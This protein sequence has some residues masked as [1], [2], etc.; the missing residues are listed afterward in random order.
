MQNI[1]LEKFEGPLDLLLELIERQKLDICEVALAQVTDQYI[2]ILNQREFDSGELA[3][4][5]L[6]ASRLLLIKS[7]ALLPLLNLTEEEEEEIRDLETALTEYR[8]YKNQAKVVKEILAARNLVLTRSL[9][10]GREMFFLPP[11]NLSL[12]LM[13]AS[14][15]KLGLSLENFLRPPES[16]RLEKTVSVEEKI[17]EIIGRIEARA[18]LSFTNLAGS[19]KRADLVISFLAILFLFREKTIRLEQTRNFGVINITKCQQ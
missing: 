9:W 8:R 16:G 2:E 11:Q 3:D 1:K 15:K 7:R 4:F 12:T 18:R 10:Q 5:L 14:L 17:K 19:G 6:V 13:V